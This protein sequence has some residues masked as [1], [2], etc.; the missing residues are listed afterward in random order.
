MPYGLIYEVLKPWRGNVNGGVTPRPDAR[1]HAS[2]LE[3]DTH[4]TP[5]T[6]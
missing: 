3:L 4:P 2:R 5:H 6:R 1:P